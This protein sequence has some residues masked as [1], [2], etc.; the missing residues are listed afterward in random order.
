MADENPLWGVPRI[1]GEILKLGF[2]I[3]ALNVMRFIPKKIGRTYSQQWN[4]FLRNHSGEIIIIDFLAVPTI[5]YQ[6][7]HDLFFHSNQRRKIIHFNVT[8]HPP[9][10]W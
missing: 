9:T 6:I 10:E 1:Y 3:S 5:N 8:A 4:T 7:L 2:D